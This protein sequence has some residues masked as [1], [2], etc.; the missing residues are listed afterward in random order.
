M[1]TFKDF[2]IK[3]LME[4]RAVPG[5]GPDADRPT[6]V[7]S[8]RMAPPLPHELYSQYDDVPLMPEDEEEFPSV[9]THT[10]Q[11]IAK[12]H[13][14]PIRVIRMELAQGVK[15]EKEHTTK[16]SKAREIALDHLWERPDYYTRLKKMEKD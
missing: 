4:F 8:R 1:I 15:V 14:V 16:T 9:K 10:V 7:V 2:L 5:V 11:E 13:K 6:P 12:K 3:D